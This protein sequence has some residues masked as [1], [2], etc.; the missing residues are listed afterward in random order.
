MAISRINSYQVKFDSAMAAAHLSLRYSRQRDISANWVAVLSREMALGRFT[1][2]TIKYAV[3][4]TE[5]YMINGQHTLTAIIKAGVSLPLPVEEFFVDSDEDIAMLYAH[6]DLQRKRGFAD[7][8]RAFD[9]PER[10]GLTRTYIENV[11]SALKWCKSNF[12]ADSKMFRSITQD[13]LREWVPNWAWEMKQMLRA[14]SPCDSASRNL[15]L[16]Q[17]VLSVALMTLR[18]SPDKATEFWRQVAQDDGL[19]RDDPRKTVRE[20]LKNNTIRPTNTSQSVSPI[21]VSRYVALGWN[22][23]YEGRPL[24]IL[25]VRDTSAVLK[26]AGT[27]FSGNQSE[28]FLPLTKSSKVVASHASRQAPMDMPATP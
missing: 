15:V 27:S 4:G 9:M 20:W 28:N 11:A 14:I 6:E 24:K 18:Y 2:N 26:L 3:L 23:W 25:R 1:T 17:S 7:S 19:S 21:S 12:G 5:R 10:L 8:M 22:A 13:D 16:K